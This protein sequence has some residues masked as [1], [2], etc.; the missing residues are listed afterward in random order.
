MKAP[1]GLEPLL[2]LT[3]L[4]H[5][6]QSGDVADTSRLA[7]L[8]CLLLPLER[9]PYYLSTLWEFTV[10]A[11]PTPHT[12]FMVDAMAVLRTLPTPKPDLRDAI[13]DSLEE[14]LEYA[15]RR[16]AD[17]RISRDEEY[18]RAERLLE[19]FE[20]MQETLRP[21]ADY[22]RWQLSTGIKGHAPPLNVQ[23]Y[24]DAVRLLYPDSFPASSPC[25]CTRD[26]EG[27]VETRGCSE[28]APASRSS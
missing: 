19:Q 12:K 23:H 25:T 24:E 14:Q 11:V 26:G 17:A 22:R 21:F 27:F 1:S 2:E 16:V 15:E 13:A 4:K 3:E 5:G 18:Q 9:S 20:A 7:H 28:H 10:S 8:P 6:D